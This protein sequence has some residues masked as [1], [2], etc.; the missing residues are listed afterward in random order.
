LRDAPNDET[1]NA[2]LNSKKSPDRCEN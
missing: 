1:Q 2:K